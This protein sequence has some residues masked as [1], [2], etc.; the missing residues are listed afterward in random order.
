MED[1]ELFYRRTYAQ[2]LGVLA[3]VAGGREDGADLCQDAYSKAARDWDRVGQ[4]DSPGAWV[5]RVG[6][7]AAADLRRRNGS[8][9]RALRRLAP[10]QHAEHL[11]DVSL[12]V[13]DALAQLPLPE[14]QVVVLHHLLS[15]TTSEIAEEL[16]RPTGTVKAQLVRG[17]QRLAAA[18]R[19]DPQEVP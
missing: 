6:L 15:L 3:T 4:L 10:G 18:L 9:R 16:L 14:R 1:F 17:R 11:D 13:L 19:L 7:N 12:E 2:T 8:Q 5:R